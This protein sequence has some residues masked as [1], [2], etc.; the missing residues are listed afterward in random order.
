MINALYLVSELVPSGPINQALNIVSGFDKSEVN[1]KVVTLFDERE[2]S[3][4]DKYKSRGI[5]VIQL[6]LSRTKLYKA[7]KLLS[8]IINRDHINVVHSSGFCADLVNCSLSKEVL[9][10]TTVRSHISDICER[11]NFIT[12]SIV[13]AVFR[14]AINHICIRVCC[15]NSLASDLVQHTGKTCKVVQNGADIDYFRPI[16]MTEKKALRQELS[17]PDNKR[18]FLS[19]GNL[20]RRKNMTLLI[21][22]MNCI[23]NKS[24]FLVILGDGVEYQRLK[25]K[26]EGNPNIFLVG[27]V[28]DPLRYYQAAD[29]FISSSFA[30]GLPNTVL[31][32]MSC[33]LP[34]ILSNIA[35]HSEMLLYN[36]DAGTLFNHF[37]IQDA[38]RIMKESE[39][40]DLAH[41]ANSARNLILENLSKY[42]TSSNY[43]NIY[44][45]GLSC[46]SKNDR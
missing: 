46:R 17:L 33:G 39:R 22:A 42:I 8:D 3:W 1:A 43:A 20:E 9:T 13:R 29:V 14:Y 16:S 40:W 18:I 19:V 15:S 28:N 2:K 34:C 44:K 37:E 41:M 12:S 7:K 27:S 23:G 25:E 11:Q 31:E 26:T 10:I 24:Y 36:N 38:V 6:H 45:E 30:E 35:P 32:A 5:E 21:D 4:L